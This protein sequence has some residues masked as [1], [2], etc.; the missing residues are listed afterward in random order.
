MRKSKIGIILVIVASL[1]IIANPINT[2]S[3]DVN[4]IIKPMANG[5]GS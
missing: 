1:L 3:V 4:S 5:M 2:V